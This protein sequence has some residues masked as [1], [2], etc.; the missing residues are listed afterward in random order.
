[1]LVS[2]FADV[3]ESR[4]AYAHANRY[5]FYSNGDAVLLERAADVR[6]MRAF[7]ERRARAGRQAYSP[8]RSA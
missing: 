2:A 1:M 4:A 3:D 7:S 6:G 5:R 8:R